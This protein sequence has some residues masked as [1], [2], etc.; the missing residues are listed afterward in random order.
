[1]CATAPTPAYLDPLAPAIGET[2]PVIEDHEA[3]TAELRAD[4]G[5][6]RAATGLEARLS[7][8]KG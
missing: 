8:R 6:Q 5:R 1:M 4:E 2:F 7:G 3:V